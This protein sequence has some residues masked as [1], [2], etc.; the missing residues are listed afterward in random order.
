[1]TWD[2]PYNNSIFHVS[3]FT[4]KENEVVGGILRDLTEPEVRKDEITRRARQVI[5]E[6]LETVQQIAFLL[7]ESASKTE[8]TLNSI[9]EA[10]QVSQKLSDE[11]EQ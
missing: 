8:K 5:R 3:V 10:Q 7:G 9:I 1:M 6:N 11:P 4:I 2:V